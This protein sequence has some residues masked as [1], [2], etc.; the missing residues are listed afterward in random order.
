[1]AV[2]AVD[3]DLF[4]RNGLISPGLMPF[5]AGSL[6]ALF[7]AAAGVEILWRHRAERA[8]AKA[9]AAAGR[10]PKERVGDGDED[11]HGERAIHN[12]RVFVVF[13]LTLATI[14]GSPV[15]GFI[16]AFGLLILVLLVFVEREAWW[17]GVLIALVASLA[18]WAIFDNFLRIPLPGG[19]FW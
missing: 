3:Y 2:L 15:V 5:L 10:T 16:P 7:G 9:Q 12:R 11:E 8:K 1:M 17:M 13:G 14:L 4:G 19:I 18:T 6:V